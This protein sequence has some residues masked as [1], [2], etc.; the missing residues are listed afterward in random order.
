MV[1]DNEKKDNDIAVKKEKK[2]RKK[3]SKERSNEISVAN[4][5]K[6]K[7]DKISPAKVA[8]KRF[9]DVEKKEPR[10]AKKIRERTSGEIYGLYPTPLGYSSDIRVDVVF[11][12]GVYQYG[13]D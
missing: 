6:E 10:R 2:V 9:K 1:E 5:I 12:E 11:K 7:K 3:R 8:R 4:D 13:L